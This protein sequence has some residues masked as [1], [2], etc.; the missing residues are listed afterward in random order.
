[1]QHLPVFLEISGGEV[2]PGIT[3]ANGV[4]AYAG[5]PLTH[6]DYAQSCIFATGHLKDGTVN[7]AVWRGSCRARWIGPLLFR[8]SRP[9]NRTP[10][11]Q[12]C[13]H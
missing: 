7:L 4:A 10:S 13:S 3:A 6:P 1:M 2:V 8:T 12:S 11:I 5:I 9:T